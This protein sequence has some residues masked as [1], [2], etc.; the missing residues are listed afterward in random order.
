MSES[1]REGLG[2]FRVRVGGR[3]GPDGVGG[4]C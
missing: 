1:E 4:R 2:A 3:I